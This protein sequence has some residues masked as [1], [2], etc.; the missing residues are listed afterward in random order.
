MKK[1]LAASLILMSFNSIGQTQT[2]DLNM[3][4]YQLQFSGANGGNNRIQS[5]GGSFPG[6]WLFKSKYDN[7]KIDAGENE[8]NLYKIL[9]MTGGIERA[10]V[11]SNGYF[12]IGTGSPASLLDVRTPTNKGLRVNYN[13]E[14]AITFVPNNGNTVFHLSHGHDNKLY[15]SQGSTV[16]AGK[17]MTFVNTGNVG[18][19]STSPNEKLHVNGN[20]AAYEGNIILYNSGINQEDSGVIRWNE[21]TGSN[22]SKAGAFIKYNGS[23]NYLQ[24][25]TNTENTEYEHLRINRG[26]SLLIQPTSGNV[27]IGTINPDSKL[28]V[29]GNIHSREVKVTVT[30]G[31]DFVFENDYNLP[32]LRSIEEYIKTNKH[33]PE[34]AAAFEMKKNGIYLSEMNIKLLQKIEELTLYTIAQE[35]NIVKQSHKIDAL[36]NENKKIKTI[37][38]KLIELQTRIET[39][40]TKN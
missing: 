39:L 8:F 10:R 23:S 40:E 11:N 33:L 21:Y 2:Q 38:E 1:I 20:I 3:D 16:G 4:L 14:S 12:G 13:N 26:G 24:I 34:I 18:I 28:T 7:I 22:T 15:L 36:E 19:G 9:F 29:A 31:A 27:G 30:A 5:F 17:L 37:N 32:S 35:K 6:T 25:M